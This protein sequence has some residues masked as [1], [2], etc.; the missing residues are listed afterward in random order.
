MINFENERACN[1]NNQDD[2]GDEHQFC[3]CAKQLIEM[4]D[5]C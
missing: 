5:V 2:D 4:G 1:K 3:H